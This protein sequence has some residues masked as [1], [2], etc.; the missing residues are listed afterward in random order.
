MQGPALR[1]SMWPL[2][3][4][5]TIFLIPA[6]V[7]EIQNTP[8][9]F[10]ID[11]LVE[12]DLSLVTTTEFFVRVASSDVTASIVGGNRNVFLGTSFSLDASWSLNTICAWRNKNW[13]GVHVV[14]CC[15]AKGPKHESHLRK[16]QLFCWDPACAA[17]G[18]TMPILAVPPV[19]VEYSSVQLRLSRLN[20][21][22]DNAPACCVKQSYFA[23]LAPSRQ[24]HLASQVEAI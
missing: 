1:C 24:R 18:E 2:P 9:A 13:T 11:A 23:Y 7:L 6:H 4:D 19:C 22:L 16:H 12:S 17:V 14:V 10:V 3:S 15:S 21:R 5:S 20:I 8:H